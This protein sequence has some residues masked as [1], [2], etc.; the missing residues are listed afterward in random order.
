MS[1][2]VRT[3]STAI[4]L[5]SIAAFGACGI[6]Q[7]EHQKTLDELAQSQKRLAALEAEVRR[8]GG[9][10]TNVSNQASSLAADKA[11]AENQLDATKAELEELRKQR[12]QLEKRMKTF[13]DLALRLKSMV[14]SGKIAVQIR[15]GKM[16]VKL[17]DNVL[18]PAG[19]ATL[20]KEG[21][22][23]LEEVAQALKT[24]GDRKFVVAGHTDNDAISTARF[25]SNWELSTQ[26]AVEVVKYLVTAG[27]KP[28]NVSAAGFGEFDPVGPNDNANHKQSN[29]RIEIIVMPNIDELPK[30]DESKT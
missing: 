4:A 22:T 23:A 16:L 3:L 29:R 20:K 25:P 5:L 7:E 9:D 13:R 19:S 14:D 10:L 11:Q 2:Y 8:L 15:D 24:I 17:P 18:F 12:E 21:K 30:F 1:S 26:R 27:M 6:P 28:K